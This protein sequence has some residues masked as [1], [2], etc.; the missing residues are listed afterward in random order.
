MDISSVC[1]RYWGKADRNYPGEPK[2][3]PLV[4]HSLDVAAVAAALWACSQAI[5]H[6]FKTAFA[7]DSE[8]TLR[9]WVLFFVALHDLGKLHIPFQIK[10][11]DVLQAA[12]PDINL[13]DVQTNRPYD[14]GCN[15]FAQ[16]DEG[17]EIAA[18]I[19]TDRRRQTR[20][21]ADWLAVVAGHHG[22]ICQPD[23]DKL[24]RGYATP[25][26]KHRDATA[27]RLWVEQ[28]ARLF[29]APVG[30]S[31]GDVPKMPDTA[32]KNLL[33]GFCSLCD[34]IGSNT[35]LFGYQAPS[36]TPAEYFAWAQDHVIHEDALAR[37]GLTA[38]VSPYGGLAVLLKGDEQPRG[39]QTMVDEL[40]VSDGLT[41]VEAPTGSGKTEAALAHAWR[42]LVA[43]VADS[44][45]FAL[46]TQAT[47][48]A[49][50]ARAAAFAQHAFGPAN[51]VLAHGHRDLNDQFRRLVEAARP[52]T[53]Q[54]HEE[55]GV[56]CSDWL[57]S[58]R[59]RVFLGQIGVCTIDQVLLSVLPIR[60]SFVRGFG[61]NRSVLI[62]DEVHAYDAYMN[63]LLEEVLRR[64]K[65]TGGSAILLSATLPAAVRRD[66]L[67]AWECEIPK[68]AP[69]PALWTADQGEARPLRL[70][71]TQLPEQREVAVELCRLADALPDE[72]LLDRIIAAA[73]AGALVGIVMNLVDDAQR[74][75][76]LLRYKA[77]QI[78]VD[79]FHARYRLRDRQGI[80]HE[81][82]TRYGRDAD[83]STGRILVATQVIEQSLD[84]DFDWLLTQLCPVDL[85]FQR[86]GRLHRHAR[87]HRPPGYEQ[88]A[89]TILTVAE[90]DYGLHEKI[91]GD[92][93]LLWR[94]EQLLSSHPSIPFPVAYRDWIEAVYASESAE[95]VDWPDEPSEV[96]EDHLA[97]LQT[98]KTA[99]ADAKRLITMTVSQF[100]DED[101]RA[102]S[103]TRD[104]EMSL[105]LLPMLPDGRLLDGTR[106]AD[107][108]ERDR[109]ETLL[110]DTVPVPASWKD[111][112]HGCCVD[113]D[114]YDGRYLIAMTEEGEAAWTNDRHRLRYSTDY[115]ME[116]TDESA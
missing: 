17:G 98:Q 104:G 83:R 13:A 52:H 14:H 75:A 61:L 51:V 62:V 29:L 68:T 87:P 100:R 48:N 82:L 36:K 4:Y 37:F 18:W 7:A 5:R 113:N 107:L 31:L 76:R 27:R 6:R 115:G 23:P 35:D 60:H 74:L 69:Y 88:P 105:S 102:T 93:R 44:V 32:A 90:P 55:A 59:K 9:T 96:L 110:L 85:L 73:R 22:S 12:W 84:L 91:Y 64:Q 67:G 24:V 97:W 92:P 78:P 79:L 56:Q 99:R 39:V 114:L 77:G 54:G 58:S 21:F 25:D 116:K 106:I 81:I 65:A 53:A 38:P 2:W 109:P 111:R 26:I 63:G 43:G 50:L 101:S 33:A 41:I 47:A 49:M 11:P 95:E 16:A 1:F 66:L 28:A 80:E 103:L 89:C 112:L 57:A 10:A 86:L 3:H 19:G 42:L 30:L 94:T 40:P 72:A 70:P 71:A 108:D 46:P 34:W 15:G 45:V 20:A 8:E